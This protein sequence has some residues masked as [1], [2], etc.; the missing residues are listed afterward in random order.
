LYFIVVAF[1]P[2]E[3]FEEDRDLERDTPHSM[4]SFPSWLIFIKGKD[5]RKTVKI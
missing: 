5:V 2:Y 4:L 3:Q 1:E